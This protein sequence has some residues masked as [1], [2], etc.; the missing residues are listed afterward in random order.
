L[1]LRQLRS[2]TASRDHGSDDLPMKIYWVPS[3][4]FATSV[5]LGGCASSGREDSNAGASGSSALPTY[6]QRVRFCVSV[7]EAGTPPPSQ[8]GVERTECC[9]GSEC[10]SGMCD[11]GACAAPCGASGAQC[12]L[13]TQSVDCCSQSCTG[14]GC[15]CIGDFE[16]CQTDRDCCSGFCNPDL[17]RCQFWD[18]HVPPLA[19]IAPAC[20]SRDAGLDGG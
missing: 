6:Q 2:P 11:H 4:V 7:A 14:S 8:C 5:G 10:C 3:V 9:C 19:T 13:A 1:S 18:A 20:F 16:L 15:S 12:S 17:S